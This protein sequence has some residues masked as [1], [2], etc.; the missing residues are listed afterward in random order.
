MR[1]AVDHAEEGLSEMVDE[2]S[3]LS[4]RVE[5]RA[6]DDDEFQRFLEASDVI[7]CPYLKSAFESRT[8]GLVVDAMILGKPVVALSETWLGDLITEE[9]FGVAVSDDPE[10]IV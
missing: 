8:S 7:V 6:L 10:S 2:L 3:S 5:S 1:A 4:V 9:N